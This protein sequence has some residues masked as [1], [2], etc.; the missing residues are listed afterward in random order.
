MSLI[1][2][3]NQDLK[4]AMKTGDEAAKRALRGVKA[5]ITRAEKDKGNQPLTDDEIIAVLRKQAKQRQDSIEA[6]RQAGREDLVKE[7]MEELA[8]IERYLPQLMDEEEIRKV[9]EKVIAE[10]GASSP[11]DMGKVMGKLMAQLKGKADGRLVNQ[12]VRELLS[13]R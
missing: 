11:R 13:G 6:Y 4:T 2:T 1:D 9:A 3:L 5:A 8:V 12:V 10:V 7:E